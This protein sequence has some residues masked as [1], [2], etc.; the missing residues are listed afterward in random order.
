VQWNHPNEEGKICTVIAATHAQ[1]QRWKL[2]F[3]LS[4]EVN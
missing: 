2:L 4:G 1:N 3:L